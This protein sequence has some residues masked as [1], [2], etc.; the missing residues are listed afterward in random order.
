MIVKRPVRLR[1]GRCVMLPPPYLF[2]R[3]AGRAIRIF[4]AAKDLAPSRGGYLALTKAAI[5]FAFRDGLGGLGRSWRLA[6]MIMMGASNRDYNRWLRTYATL[7]DKGRQHIREQI[8]LWQ[9]PPLISIVMP[10][11]NPEISWLKEAIESV[12]RQLYANWELCIADDM[13]T[14]DGVKEFLEACTAGDKRIKVTYRPANGHI[15]EAS[16]SAIELATGTWMALLDQDDLLT[17]D[18]LFYVARALIENPE[19]DLVYSD[20]DKIANGRRFD[21]NFKPDWNLELLRSHNLVSHLGVYRLDRVRAIGGFRKGYEGAQ[22]Y[23]LVLRFTEG[24]YVNRIKHIPRVLYHWRVHSN[25]TAQT[26]GNKGYAV[27]AG[28]KALGEHLERLG[29]GATVEVLDTDMYR[30][31]YRL[32]EKLPL[33]S[34]IIPTR[35]GLD[36]VHQCVSS[37]LDKTSYPTYEIIIVDNN[38]DDPATLAYFRDI[39]ADLRVRV[40]RDERPFNYSALNN[41]AVALS[42]G[43]YVGLIN[44]DIEVINP[45]WLSELMKLAI[46]DGVG[47]VGA[48]LWYPDDTLQHGGVIVGLGGV[49]GH[50]HKLLKRGMPGYFRRAELP[51]D[52]S[53]VTAACLVVS[54]PIFNAVGGLN[55]VDLTVAFNDVDFCLKLQEAGHR[56]VWTPYAELYHHES[57]SR[58]LEDTPEKVERFRQEIAYMRARWATHLRPDP[59]YNPNLTLNY[60]DFSLAWPPRNQ[61]DPTPAS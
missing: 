60:E 57:A 40:E 17:E 21:P 9:N 30:T 2:V 11:Y 15:S 42:A 61:T 47:A 41:R 48:R 8:A 4:R 19:L 28:Q 12:R 33:V 55:E 36:L 20:E 31:R 50:S 35:N 25:S 34:L 46:Q 32:P 6:V 53:A 16:N 45:D 58:G 56:N 44:N 26:S 38:S 13:S 49:A 18:A 14:R 24:L 3:Q 27:V 51:Q 59:A 43:E 7:D 5:R 54:K 1:G 22:D 29:I 52:L 39:Q 37:I 10:V 23:D